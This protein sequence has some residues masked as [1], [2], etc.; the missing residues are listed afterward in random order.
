MNGC[1][2]IVKCNKSK[3]NKIM[4]LMKEMIEISDKRKFVLRSAEEADAQELID[5]M[6]ATS[7]ETYFMLRYPEEVCNDIEMEKKIIRDTLESDFSVFLTIFDG[8]TVIGNCGI[9]PYR[10]YIKTKH[11]C[12]LGIAIRKEYWGLGLGSLLIDKALIMANKMG[13]SQVELG[14]FSDNEKAIA[15]YTKKGFCEYGRLPKAYRLKDGTY[16]D[17]VMMV[18]YL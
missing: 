7:G 2:W 9:V 13:Y 11:R 16:L 17:E 1:E 8:D 6:A 4:R 12:G 10:Q 5:Y 14:A 18:H 3:E 15:L